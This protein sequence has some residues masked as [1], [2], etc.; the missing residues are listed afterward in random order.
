MN[1]EHWRTFLNGTEYHCKEFWPDYSRDV[2]ISITVY[3]IMKTSSSISGHS[4]TSKQFVFLLF[5][6]N[7][8]FCR[9]QGNFCI[10]CEDKTVLHLS[11]ISQVK[12]YVISGIINVMIFLYIINVRP[13]NQWEPQTLTAF[14]GIVYN[15]L[16]GKYYAIFYEH[17][18]NRDFNFLGAVTILH[19]TILSCTAL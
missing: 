7:L 13:F 9:L 15:V 17:I 19:Y 2:M 5:Q 16:T 18:V 4:T 10:Y 11:K 6:R 1:D 3:I 12:I 14:Y 8:S